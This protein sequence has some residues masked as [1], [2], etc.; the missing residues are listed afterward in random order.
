MCAGSGLVW[1]GL[2]QIWTKL[3]TGFGREDWGGGM[4]CSTKRWDGVGGLG[5]MSGFDETFCRSELGWFRT[6]VGWFW[7]NLGCFRLSCGPPVGRVYLGWAD[8]R[9]TYLGCADHIWV[10]A[11][12]GWRLKF[13]MAWDEMRRGLG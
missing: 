1:A 4:A 5:Q 9:H 12:V 6:K 3:W 10:R 2:D 8:V 11:H 7:P 13:G